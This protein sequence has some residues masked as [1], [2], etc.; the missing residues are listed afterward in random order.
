MKTTA[1]IIVSSFAAIVC[2]AAYAGS[3]PA[4]S[5]SWKK[6]PHVKPAGK[7]DSNIKCYVSN[8]VTTPW[9]KPAFEYN[10]D[11]AVRPKAAKVI[12]VIYNPVLE[13]QG[14]KTLIEFLNANDPREFSRILAESIREC[15]GGY[16][17]Y[18]IVDI[19]ERDEFTEIGSRIDLAGAL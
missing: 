18:D 16:M 7:Q 9:K 11:F 3:Q 15:S 1:R 17:N 14:N 12:V 2:L 4:C 13:S 19:I 5:P 8:P 10:H 6:L